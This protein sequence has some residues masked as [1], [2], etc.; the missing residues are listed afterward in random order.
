MI[1]DDRV[2]LLGIR[3]HGPGSAISVNNALAEIQPEVILLEGPPELEPILEWLGHKE[4]SLPVAALL[5]DKKEV[6][7][8]VLYPFADYSPELQAIRYANSVNIPL[9]MFDLPAIYSIAQRF[10]Q[11]D[12]LQAK[13]A[14]IRTDD[15]IHL[16]ANAAGFEDSEAWWNFVVEQRKN[17]LAIFVAIAEA[18]TAVREAVEA[19]QPESQETYVREAWMRKILRQTLS[20]YKGKIAVICGAWHVPAL[21]KKVKVTQD[22]AL[23]KGLAKCAVHSTWIPWT[24][25]RLTFS[26]GYGAG[27]EY[28]GWYEHIWQHHHQNKALNE[29]WLAKVAN[30]LRDEGVDVSTASLIEAVRLADTLATMRGFQAPAIEE[31]NEAITT[32]FCFGDDIYL[33]LIRKKLLIGH[34]IGQVPVEAPKMALQQDFEQQLKML[35][36]KISDEKELLL[37]LRKELHVKRS[38]FFHRLKL[39]GLK[40]ALKIPA[41]S[42]KGTFKEAWKLKWEAEFAIDIVNASTF[43]NSILSAATQKTIQALE[44]HDNID[45]IIDLLTDLLFAELASVIQK[46]MQ[47]L[48]E[49]VAVNA[50]LQ[51]LMVALP[52]LVEISR[53]GN[54]RNTEIEQV[55]HLVRNILPRICHR[56]PSACYAIDEEAAREMASRI[57][58]CDVA[59]NTF[60]EAELLALWQSTLSQLLDNPQIQGLIGG[61]VCRLLIDH[62]VITAEDAA[63]RLSYELSQGNEVEH[64]ADWIQGLL[65]GAALLLIHHDRLWMLVDEWLR[66]IQAERFIELLPILRRAFSGFESG[67]IKQLL[68]KSGSQES[69]QAKVNMEQVFNVERAEM[70]L[71]RVSELLGFA[72]S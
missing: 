66:G 54:V 33:K 71:V 56:L 44:S 57:E 27:I 25:E 8:S 2:Y 47:K 52:G 35:R 11:D 55:N 70:A 28:P 30:L 19:E 42:G 38:I 67:E 12:T 58:R 65:E 45:Y 14:F 6:G 41:V 68:S 17:D 5:Y 10:A 69:L 37:D 15:P 59:T 23:I 31:F 61:K 48:Q 18:M 49:I 22:N 26:S 40:F 7:H 20:K 21:M 3:H 36:L 63:V 60:A 29:T 24:N 32:T 46:A 51:S 13:E 34:R 1:L 43:G 72:R 39:L 50:E 4:M 9:Q 64:E 53:Y 62:Q 16:L